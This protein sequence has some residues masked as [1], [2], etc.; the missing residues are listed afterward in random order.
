M[1][2]FKYI[3]ILIAIL[4]SVNIYSFCEHHNK[5]EC[6]KFNDFIKLNIVKN[7]KLADFALDK[8]GNKYILLNTKLDKKDVFFISKIDKNQKLI[9]SR[10]IKGLAHN[11]LLN[12]KN[13]VIVSSDITGDIKLESKNYSFNTKSLLILKL[14]HTKGK[15]KKHLFISTNYSVV[16]T[17]L[18][19]DGDDIYIAGYY[20]G[21]SDILTSS[22]NIA[23]EDAFLLVLDINLKKKWA[24]T[25]I[26]AGFNY[27]DDIKI[28]SENIYLS[29]KRSSYYTNTLMKIN[30]KSPKAKPKEL[31]SVNIK[32]FDI[33][34]N[35]NIYLINSATLFLMKYDKD[36]KEIYNKE[37]NKSKKFLTPSEVIVKNDSL[38]IK[39]IAN[40]DY[41]KNILISNYNLELKNNWHFAIIGQTQTRN[42][43]MIFN[44]NLFLFGEFNSNLTFLDKDFFTNKISPFIL[45]FNLL[46]SKL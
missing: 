13:E 23:Y 17:A 8:T 5:K 43:L 22:K 31:K 37:L 11:I 32:S 3:T 15:L 1:S 26:K 24:R 46:P 4:L 40:V 27:I 18:S 21:K 14:E 28:F 16:P 20:G 41:K 6:L 10:Y 30:K 45:D 38:F 29:L 12:S 2:I 34:A 9:W 7:S 44:N 36:F 42:K 33:D 35:E 25:F 39:Y 19:L